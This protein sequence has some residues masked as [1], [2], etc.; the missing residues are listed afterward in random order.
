MHVPR[1]TSERIARPLERCVVLLV[2]KW[3]ENLVGIIII[4]VV[5]IIIISNLSDDRSKAS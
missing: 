1:V 2:M 3:A 5:V 4:V